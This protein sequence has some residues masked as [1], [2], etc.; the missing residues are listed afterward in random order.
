[1]PLDHAAPD[2]PGFDL[3]YAEAGTDHAGPTLVLLP[4][5]P[6]LA[7]VLPYGKVRKRLAAH[8]LHVVTPEHRGVGLSRHTPDG[9][10]LPGEVVTLEQAAGDVLAVRDAVGGE[11]A[12]LAGTSYGGYLALEAA[13]RAPGRFEALVL[14][15]A[16][17][18]VSGPERDRQRACFWDG[19]E[20]GFARRAE[21]VRALA[22]AGI[23]SDDELAAVVPF[24]Y[25]LAGF[26]ALDALLTRAEGGH[27]KTLKRVHRLAALEVEGGRKPL[28]FDGDL[29]LP[30]WL[31]RMAPERPDGK[32]FDRARALTEVRT[33]HPNVPDDPF[34]ATLWLA[35]LTAPALILQGARDMRVPPAAVDE[36]VMGL[37]AARRIIF[38]NAGHDLLRLRTPDVPAD[39][40]GPGSRRT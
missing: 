16:A 23:V 31:G 36:L 10:L 33:A 27:V 26:E 28:V 38:A 8:G 4:G 7:S 21:R 25:E 13:R 1:M 20:N 24:V 39:P 5:G 2:G 14:D 32:P 29:T 3:A 15:S 9:L 19:T 35:E 6:G 11:R 17:A 34:D 40:R 22:A 18:T 30:I 12:I 37:P